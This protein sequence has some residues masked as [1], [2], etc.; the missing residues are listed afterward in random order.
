MTYRYILSDMIEVLV[1][2]VTNTELNKQWPPFGAKICWDI[3][4]RTN[5]QGQISEHI[6]T[7]NGELLRNARSFENWGISSDI[8]SFS[9]GIFTYVTRLDQ[10]RARENI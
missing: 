4:S 10:S 6:F 8:P 3:C 1:N 2:L 5:V 9:W 7:P